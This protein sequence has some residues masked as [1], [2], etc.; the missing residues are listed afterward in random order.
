[1]F[2]SLG[3]KVAALGETGFRHIAAEG[4]EDEMDSGDA[5]IFKVLGIM[6]L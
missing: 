6:G 4:D 5:G 3:G 1:L 2:P